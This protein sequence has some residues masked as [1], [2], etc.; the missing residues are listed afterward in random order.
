MDNSTMTMKEM[1]KGYANYTKDEL[2]TIWENA[3]IAVDANILLNFYRYSE[4]TRNRILEILKGLKKRLWIPYQVGKEFFDNRITVMVDSYNDYDNLSSSITKNLDESI[5][6]I[7]K[8]KNSQLQC[9]SKIN[10]VIEK[11]KNDIQE[12]LDN[13]KKQKVPHY[14]NDPIQKSILT[15]ID[16]NIGK[17][18]EDDEYLT[19]KEEGL[20]RFNEKI[21]PGYKD[22]NKEEN[23]DYYIFYSLM[24]K[25]KQDNKD[26]IFITDDAKEDWFIKVN[27]EKHG[28]RYELLDEFHKETGKLLMIYTSDGFVEQYDKSIKHATDEKIITELKDVRNITEHSISDF[29]SRDA[30]FTLRRYKRMLSN[31]PKELILHKDIILDY[32]HYMIK[33]TNMSSIQREELM[34]KFRRIQRTIYHLEDYT[35]ANQLLLDLIQN[36]IF[37][38]RENSMLS[39]DYIK[40]NTSYIINKYAEQLSKLKNNNDNDSEIEQLDIYYKLHSIITEHIEIINRSPLRSRTI[41]LITK[42][43]DLSKLVNTIIQER[44]FSR[45]DEVIQLIELLIDYDNNLETV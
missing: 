23:G 1:F 26:I 3:L 40:F 8:K 44:D 17:K 18:F 21:P 13:E 19:V 37:L 4:D 29:I 38:S 39:S 9:K 45:K 10:D 22:S 7:N 33:K 32:V 6:E 20:R 25:S 43:N 27:G 42:L 15:L 5:N 34:A 24:K 35:L 16:T 41:N 11:A 28:G 31:S 36:L 12:L 30:N 14:E 2:A